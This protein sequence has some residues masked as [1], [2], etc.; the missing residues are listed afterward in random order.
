MSIFIE[1]T[2]VIF[3]NVS[4][5]SKKS[6]SVNIKTPFTEGSLKYSVILP[7]STLSY[8]ICID[9]DILVVIKL[10]CQGPYYILVKYR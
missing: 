6:L 7:R 2:F 4:L 8:M 5:A 10:N 1:D 3:V 9:T